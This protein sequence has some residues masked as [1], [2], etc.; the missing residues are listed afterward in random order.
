[1]ISQLAAAKTRH[2]QTMYPVLLNNKH[3]ATAILKSQFRRVLGVQFVKANA[4]LKLERLHLVR[5][6]REETASLAAPHKSRPNL[7]YRSG[8]PYWFTQHCNDGNYQGWY[9]FRQSRHHYAH[10]PRP[11]RAF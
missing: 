9:G 3:G 1:M 2:G 4:R 5:S 8:C 10:D 11:T 7:N 6:T